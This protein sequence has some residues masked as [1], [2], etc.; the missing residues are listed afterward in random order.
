MMTRRGRIEDHERWMGAALAGGARR[1][2]PRRRPDRRGRRARRRPRDRA[3]AATS[4]SCARTRP[5]TPRCWRCA[6]PPPRWAPGACWT[7]TLYVT[8]E[9]C[10]MCAGAIVLARVPRVVYATRRP[11]GRRGRQRPRR[12]RRRRASTTA[13]RSSAACWPTRPPSSCGPSSAPGA[14]LSSFASP[15]RGAG[16]VE[17][18]GLENRCTASSYRGFESLP[19]RQSPKAADRRPSGVLDTIALHRHSLRML[20]V[21]TKKVTAD[22]DHEDLQQAPDHD[23]QAGLRSRPA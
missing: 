6:R 19:L 22:G 9:P 17:R 3:A 23:R 5:R 7:S 11:E 20:Q 16:V 13:P 15:W 8:L 10:T 21:V 14:R 2:G 18:G 12:P 4:A 1:D